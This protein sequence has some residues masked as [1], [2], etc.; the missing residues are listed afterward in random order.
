VWANIQSAWEAFKALMDGDF[1]TFGQKLREIWDNS[2]NMIIQITKDRANDL[3]EF[4]K[5]IPGKIKDFFTEIDW[6][7]V[8]KD[9]ILG[10]IGGMAAIG[11]IQ[12]TLIKGIVYGLLDTI[13]GFTDAHSPSKLFAD[14]AG[15]PIGQGILQGAQDALGNFGVSLGGVLTPQI[16]ALAGAGGGEFSP[17]AA[18]AS[19]SQSVVIN[20]NQPVIGFAD[21]YELA[22]KLAPIIKNYMATRA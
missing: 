15:M 12:N 22:A 14:Q 9:I 2:W 13:R 17:R 10:I 16:P 4:A 3:W 8:G 18:S 7:Q 11:E 21:E 5:T 6:S 19:G 20:F 1:Y